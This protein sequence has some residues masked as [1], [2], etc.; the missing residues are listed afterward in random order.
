MSSNG[1]QKDKQ[2]P[3]T[4]YKMKNISRFFKEIFNY[5][6]HKSPDRTVWSGNSEGILKK[7]E[8][9]CNPTTHPHHPTINNVLH[10][11]C[12]STDSPDRSRSKNTCTALGVLRNNV[13]SFSLSV[14]ASSVHRAQPDCTKDN[15]Q[16]VNRDSDMTNIH[17]LQDNNTEMEQNQKQNI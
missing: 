12:L 8:K 13:K 2:F 3:A 6:S 11:L 10:F 7:S 1:K 14:D 5:W 15:M 17:A 4:L 9:G 16:Y